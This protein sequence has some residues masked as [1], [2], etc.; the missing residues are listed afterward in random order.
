MKKLTLTLMSATALVLASNAWAAPAP[1]LHDE[2]FGAGG[3][4]P[5][6]E[7]RPEHP[8]PYPW[9]SGGYSGGGYSGG[10]YSGG[11]SSTPTVTEPEP[12]VTEEASKAPVADRIQYNAKDAAS[13]TNETNNTVSWTFSGK[14]S[15]AEGTLDAKH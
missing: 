8:Q 10:G 4:E 14:T 2:P 1:V 13:S 15:R 6:P 5:Q 11:S 3:Q 7:P 12:T 9:Q